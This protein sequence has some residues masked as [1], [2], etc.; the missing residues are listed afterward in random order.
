MKSPEIEAGPAQNVLLRLKWRQG[1]E[2]HP[3]NLMRPWLLPGVL[4]V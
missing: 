4:H 1:A 2:L 3:V